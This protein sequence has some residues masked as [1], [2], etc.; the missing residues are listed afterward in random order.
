MEQQ[1][2]SVMNI[3]PV[4]RIMSYNICYDDRSNGAN[5]WVGR[6]DKVASI[7]GFHHPDLAGLQEVL[8]HQA[9]DLLRLLPGYECFGASTDGTGKGETV[10]IFYRPER[11]KLLQQGTFWLSEQPETPGSKGWD[12]ML[13][14]IVTWGKFKDKIT[15]KKIFQFNTHFDHKGRRAQLESG[16]LLLNRI[17]EIAKDA[18]VI[19]TGDF[20]FTESAQAY[21]LLTNDRG[22]GATLYDARYTSTHKHHGPGVTFCGFKVGNSPGERIDYIFTKN[23]VK[24]WRHGTLTDAW[25]GQYPSDHLPLLAEAYV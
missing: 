18:P 2:V 24:I 3:E 25:N 8:R 5:A 13:P 21:N 23:R 6:R 20:N 9:V 12:A 4:L 11:L 15:S 17:S 19:V 14:R 7:I 22:I 1:T 10:A 16:L